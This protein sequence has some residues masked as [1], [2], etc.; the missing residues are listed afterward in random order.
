M[1][2]PVLDLAARPSPILGELGGDLS[3]TGV[4]EQSDGVRDRHRVLSMLA[5]DR[6]KKEIAERL[7]ISL[8]TVVSHVGH[9]YEKLNAPN[10]PA[11]IAKAFQLGILPIAELD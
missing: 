8:S 7:H 11:A 4:V 5:E 2:V 9:I 1:A 10:A 3:F 6:V